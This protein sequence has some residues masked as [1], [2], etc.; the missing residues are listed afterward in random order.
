MLTDPQH[1]REEREKKDKLK[2][3]EW[4]P[5]KRIISSSS[6]KII[7]SKINEKAEN[8]KMKMINNEIGIIVKNTALN[9]N[10]KSND[11]NYGPRSKSSTNNIKNDNNN[12]NHKD[13]NSASK[14]ERDRTNERDKI[15]QQ[16]KHEQDEI[17][18]QNALDIQKMLDREMIEMKL[19]NKPKMEIKEPETLSRQ[20]EVEKEVL[21]DLKKGAESNNP[22]LVIQAFIGSRK[23]RIRLGRLV[24]WLVR[25]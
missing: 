22:R 12:D 23:H 24:E 4:T 10:N 13:K 15:N 16:K 18:K 1:Q 25:G 3:K 11:I 14:N 8:D 9:N 17:N 2:V 21:L 5:K 20:Q 7:E 6:S 19:R